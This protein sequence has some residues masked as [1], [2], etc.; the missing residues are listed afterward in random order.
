MEGSKQSAKAPPHRP[1]GEETFPFSLTDNRGTV[2]PI[3]L[4]DISRRT[5]PP[6][7][8]LRGRSEKKDG[9]YPH[10]PV[11]YTHLRAHETEADL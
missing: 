8:P 5:L 6:S 9:W 4:R 2:A 3:P 1:F 10:R 7:T 11:S